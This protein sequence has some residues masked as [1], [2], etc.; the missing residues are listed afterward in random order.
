M[1]AETVDHNFMLDYFSVACERN[2]DK[3]VASCFVSICEELGISLSED[4]YVDPTTVHVFLYLENHSEHYS[5][6]RI[7]GHIR[8]CS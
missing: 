2:S 5:R 6:G 3:C 1:W 4:K 7:D 8:G